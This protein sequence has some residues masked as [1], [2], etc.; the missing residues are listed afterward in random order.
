MSSEV[1]LIGSTF[2]PAEFGKY[3]EEVDP[4][5]GKHFAKSAPECKECLAPVVVEGKLLFLRDLCEARTHGADT[6]DH[7]VRLTT[8][9]VIVRLDHGKSLQE[10]YAEI[11]GDSTSEVTAKAARSLLAARL[12]RMRFLELPTPALPPLKDL[13]KG[14]PK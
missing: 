4:C 10:I 6:P 8:N 11:L 5:F 1:V 9:D 12:S 7:L 2:P 14:K 3:L 13:Q